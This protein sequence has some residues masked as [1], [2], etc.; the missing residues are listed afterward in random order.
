MLCARPRSERLI[1]SS[2]RVLGHDCIPAFGMNSR[3]R[4]TDRKH[5]YTPRGSEF[6]PR[7]LAKPG[8]TPAFLTIEE[9]PDRLEPLQTLETFRPPKQEVGLKPKREM[10]WRVSHTKVRQHVTDRSFARVLRAV[11]YGRDLSCFGGRKVSIALRPCGALPCKHWPYYDVSLVA[12]VPRT[13]V[14]E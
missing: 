8:K 3:S 5:F 12:Y 2:D 10:T 14:S 9:F 11:L 7:W 4:R 6:V 13:D 1:V